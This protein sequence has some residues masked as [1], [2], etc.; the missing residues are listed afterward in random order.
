MWL[1]AMRAV[2]ASTASL[3]RPRAAGLAAI[4]LREERHVIHGFWRLYIGL[5]VAPP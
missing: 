3:K 5:H 4:R 1:F 2:A